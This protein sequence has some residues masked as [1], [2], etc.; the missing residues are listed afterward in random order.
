MKEGQR[1]L[2]TIIYVAIFCVVVAGLTI[3]LEAYP[4]NRSLITVELVWFRF[5]LLYFGVAIFCARVGFHNI[6]RT[7]IYELTG[8]YNF[9]VAAHSILC[10]SLD[11]KLLYWLNYGLYNL[12]VGFL[13]LADHYILPKLTSKE[14]S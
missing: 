10:Y 13:I 4:E 1:S 6:Q 8:W 9:V 11:D 12:F 7:F 5:I 2:Y 3:N 14:E